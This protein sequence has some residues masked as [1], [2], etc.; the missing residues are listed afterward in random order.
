MLCLDARYTHSRR[1]T[2]KRRLTILPHPLLRI[3]GVGIKWRDIICFFCQIELWKGTAPS[4]RAADDT[5]WIKVPIKLV[6][7]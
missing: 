1:A 6:F 5:I 4:G 2:S 7:G 3:G